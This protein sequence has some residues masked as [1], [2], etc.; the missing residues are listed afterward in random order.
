MAIGFAPRLPLERS[1]EDGYGLLKNVRSLA[2]QNLKMLLLTAP[3]ERVM[4]PNYGVGLRRYLFENDTP[5][6]ETKLTQAITRQ[7]S[8]YMPYIEIRELLILTPRDVEDMPDNS[9]QLRIVYSISSMEDE[10]FLDIDITT[11]NTK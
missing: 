3:G 9:M 7:I 11:G 5:D 8:I 4:D 6:L 1:L 10:A 2:Q